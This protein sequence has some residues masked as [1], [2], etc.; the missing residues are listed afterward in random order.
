MKKS[1]VNLIALLILIASS[2][3][4]AAESKLSDKTNNK[5]SEQIKNY[6]NNT[7]KLAVEFEQTDTRGGSARGML[8]IDKPHK[9]RLNYYDPFPLL[10]IGNKNYVSVYDYEMQHFARIKAE[11]NIFNFLLLD[12]AEFT[13]QFQIIAQKEYADVYELALYH[14]GVGRTSNVAFDKS[15]GHIRTI[16]IYEDDNVITLQFS[17]TK[18]LTK[19][20]RELFIIKDPE[21]FGTPDRLAKKDLDKLI[22]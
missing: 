13:K 14:E 5:I 4:F 19:A 2:P 10:I 11:E 21:I 6:L 12:N 9:F 18:L 15:T 7:K 3:I 8:I 1:L 16:I 17:E 22:K 20:A